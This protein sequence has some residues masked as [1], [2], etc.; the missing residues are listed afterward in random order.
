MVLEKP[1]RIRLQRSTTSGTDVQRGRNGVALGGRQASEGVAQMRRLKL[2]EGAV[3][4]SFAS[5]AT[6]WSVRRDVIDIPTEDLDLV[7][8]KTVM[9]DQLLELR[10][11]ATDRGRPVAAIDERLCDVPGATTDS[12]LWWREELCSLRVHVID[13]FHREDMSST[14]SDERTLSTPA[15]PHTK[16]THNHERRVPRIRTVGEHHVCGSCDKSEP[17]RCHAGRPRETTTHASRI[18]WTGI[19]HAGRSGNAHSSG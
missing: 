13:V 6:T 17:R 3:L 12:G 2:L 15:K 8:P 1:E 9:V 11:V 5:G 19:I 7:V 14:F 4:S 16:R 10:N 18:T